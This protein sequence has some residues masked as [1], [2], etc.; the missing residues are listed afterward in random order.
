MPGLALSVLLSIAQVPTA[1]LPYDEYRVMQ[2]GKPFGKAFVKRASLPDNGVL[3][4]MSMILSAGPQTV[5]VRIEDTYDKDGIRRSSSRIV[6]MPQ[7]KVIESSGAPFEAN[8]A[9]YFDRIKDPAKPIMFPVDA[10]LP[11]KDLSV[12]WVKTGFPAEE[13]KYGYY[14]FDLAKREWQLKTVHFQ[15]EAETK[16]GDQAFESYLMTTSGG[17]TA[18]RLVYGTG[19]RVLQIVS[20]DLEMVWD[21]AVDPKKPKTGG[22]GGN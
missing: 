1:D 21:R 8:R 20:G 15:G 13:T 22:G 6:E 14:S 2:A 16:I 4:I 18:G 3:T 12:G 9:V 11:R 5:A 19:G 10:S 7:G 17:G